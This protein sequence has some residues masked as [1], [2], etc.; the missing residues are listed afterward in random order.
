[1]NWIPKVSDRVPVYITIVALPAVRQMY[2]RAAPKEPK[3][4]SLSTAEPKLP[5]LGVAR[6]QQFV[7]NWVLL[8]PDRVASLRNSI[9][10]LLDRILK[11]SVLISNWGILSPDRKAVYI[12]L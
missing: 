10:S 9:T 12:T 7:L 8:A 2:R 4:P 1:M 6:R 11:L 3:V 5:S